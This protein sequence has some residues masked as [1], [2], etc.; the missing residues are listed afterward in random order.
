MSSPTLD[1]STAE[2]SDGTL[3]VGLSEKPDSDWKERFERTVRLLAGERADQ[4]KVK[5]GTVRLKAVEPGT[6]DDVRHLL[7]SAVLE[8]GSAGAGW[9]AGGAGDETDGPDAE[10]TARF[11]AYAE[12]DRPEGVSAA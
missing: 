11:R 1:W 6:E 8:A 12:A 5:H 7:E 3:E 2:V 9:D 10:M 4:L